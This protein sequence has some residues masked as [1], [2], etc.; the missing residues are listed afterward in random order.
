MSYLESATRADY[1][2]KLATGWFRGTGV[3]YKCDMLC[4]QEE[5]YGVQHIRYN[6]SDLKFKKR[7]ARL[8]RKNKEQFRVEITPT[9]SITQ[10][11]EELYRQ[12]AFRFGGFIHPTLEE[13][14]HTQAYSPNFPTFEVNVWD[15]EK[16]IAVSY[17]DVAQTSVAAIIGLFDHAYSNYSLGTFTMLLEM[18]F[19][20]NS[21]LHFY[22]PGY[23]LEG[24]N[25]F[26]YK[27]QMGDCEWLNEITLDEFREQGDW[28]ERSNYHTTLSPANYLREKMAELKVQLAMTGRNV[29]QRVYP[30]FALGYVAPTTL[31]LLK[32]PTY[33][34]ME[35]NGR[36]VC[37]A[38]D[39][40]R[41]RWIAFTI[42]HLSDLQEQLHLI[43]CED[44]AQGKKYELDVMRISWKRYFT[45]MEDL[46]RI[47]E[48]KFKVKE[49]SGQLRLG[50][51]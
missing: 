1:D 22:Y 37:I 10:R 29:S 14:I 27:L 33:F 30:Y 47:L 12:H 15:G 19:A 36:I 16:L 9:K 50:L 17:F 34:E 11:K 35:Y 42:R 48:Q 31:Q 3:F 43:P 8:L 5:V 18:E 2:Q 21:G 40:E 44:Y 4:M 6:L 51:S 41:D 45:S 46:E 13:I 39:P 32:L 23:V 38:M 25:A 7:H 24:C 49:E 26:D 20:L 28:V